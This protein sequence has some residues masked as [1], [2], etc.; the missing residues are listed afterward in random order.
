MFVCL[1]V[2]LFVYVSDH[3]MTRCLLYGAWA[4]P[5]SVVCHSFVEPSSTHSV[6]DASTD[7]RKEAKLIDIYGRTVRTGM[8]FSTPFCNTSSHITCHRYQAKH[9]QLSIDLKAVD[10]SFDVVRVKGYES[11]NFKYSS[12]FD[13]NITDNY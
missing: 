3:S 2:C 5:V 11:N 6:A 4:T 12:G 13:G 7:K 1:F 10:L 9:R 8:C